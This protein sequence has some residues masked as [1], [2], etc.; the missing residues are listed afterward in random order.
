MTDQIAVVTGA[1]GAIGAATARRL[2]EQGLTVLLTDIDAG[3]AHA[4]AKPCLLMESSPI[5][6]STTSPAARLGEVIAEVRTHG[7]LWATV[8]NAGLL[9]D[10]LLKR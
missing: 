8:S 3:A 4:A 9:R 1:G 6:C 5:P 10:S 7:E 2:G